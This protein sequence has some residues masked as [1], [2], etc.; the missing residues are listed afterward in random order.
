MASSVKKCEICDKSFNY[1]CGAFTQHLRNEHQMSLKEYVIKFEYNG[2]VPKCKCGYCDE[3][4]I[5]S[6]GKFLDYAVGH[7]SYNW[8]HS[9][10]IKK[11]G[12]PK[13]KQ[14][15]KE[16][17]FNRSKP[18]KYCSKS[19]A[20]KDNGWNQEKC[21]KTL[22]THYGVD[23]PSQLKTSKES[24]SRK[25]RENAKFSLEKRKKTC[26]EKYG[27]ESVMHLESSK[28]ALEKSFL[29][30]YGVKHV[31]QNKEIH[32]KQQKNSFKLHIFKN[33]NLYY[34]SSYE[35]DFLVICEN[36][37]ILNK[38]K[39]GNRF[40]YNDKVY[41]TDFS[42]ENYE[43]EIKSTWI[44]KKQGGLPILFAKRDAVES[45]G[46]KYILILDKDYTEFKNLTNS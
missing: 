11:Y 18:K 14:C 37:G 31:L 46:K 5:F 2:I 8:L 40:T 26:I 29:E 10:Y 43:I 41:F 4:A 30:K 7:T 28:I 38:L 36:L 21:Q 35:Y 12:M 15:G 20:S 34:Q 24:I 1:T 16:I 42:L 32:L 13:C 3:E 17:G 44:L 23:N 19:C 25:N 45:T 22:K 33:T 27:V 6:R 39:N 9:Q